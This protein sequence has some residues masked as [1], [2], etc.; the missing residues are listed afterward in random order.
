MA[1]ISLRDL[2]VLYYDRLLNITDSVQD[3]LREYFKEALYA[4]SLQELSEKLTTKSVHVMIVNIDEDEEDRI[5]AIKV[6]RT[7]YPRHPLL[8]ITNKSDKELDTLL[9]G[10]A[11]D[12]LLPLGFNEEALRARL[13][14][15]ENKA[16]VLFKPK[17]T[18]VKKLERSL[19]VSESI[20]IYFK[21]TV[22]ELM[23]FEKGDAFSRKMNYSIMK[24][25]L[26]TAFNNFKQ[27]DNKFIDEKLAMLKSKMEQLVR[28]SHDMDRRL[29]Y[30]IEVNY[31][32]IFLKKQI[33]YI[34]L[35]DEWEVKKEELEK[36]RND[37]ALITRQM[38]EVREQLKGVP[39]NSERAIE[40]QS[41]LK[42]LNGKNVDKVHEIKE[43]TAKIEELVARMEDFK[44]QYF[45]E[46][47]EVFTSRSEEIKKDI[48]NAMDILAYRLDRQ[49]WRRAKQSRAIRDFFEEGQIKGLISS[50]TYLEY[51]VSHLDEKVASEYSAKLIKYLNEYNKTNKI[52]VAL[53][54]LDSESLAIRKTLTESIDS[55]VS[56]TIYFD[57][58]IFLK[59]YQRTY[60]DVVV[61]DF[62]LREMS[63]LELYEMLKE[64]FQEKGAH[65][66]F[67]VNLTA[68]NKK[69]DV[70]VVRN[71][72]IKTIFTE[73]MSRDQFIRLM[74]DTL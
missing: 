11:I 61:C 2:T 38:E 19:S 46:F 42:R 4:S 22:I 31:E 33:P 62:Y 12:G 55:S 44:K 60:H 58:K 43:L 36:A 57:P 74:F 39:K 48:K 25:F 65:T 32:N 50:K 40:L 1:D 21:K 47:K 13:P 54:G 51:Y 15:I 63:A 34:E 67:C 28:L 37:L 70:M 53:I 35:Y 69:S 73:T 5:N 18:E 7:K 8:V 10:V 26:N 23:D 17:K 6:F 49:I 27:L 66:E 71:A 20:E 45:D 24:Q 64:G 9:R 72:G 29:S 41:Q 56:C 3:T 16:N 30:A 14:Q 59:D 52:S 68:R